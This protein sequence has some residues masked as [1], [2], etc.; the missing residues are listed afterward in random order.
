[1]RTTALAGCTSH[2]LLRRE[3][4]ERYFS[5]DNQRRSLEQI[6][7]KYDVSINTV[8]AHNQKVCQL[9]GGARRGKHRG[10]GLEEAALNEF[11]DI[12]QASTWV[13]K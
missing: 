4:V 6:A 2:G 13:E 3:Y 11:E 12:F 9:L 7:K 8:S 5:I 10:G 1:M